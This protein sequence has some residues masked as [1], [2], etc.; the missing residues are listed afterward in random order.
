MQ[1]RSLPG[2][3]PI[4]LLSCITCSY[5]YEC[6]TIL[7]VLNTFWNLGFRIFFTFVQVK[8]FIVLPSATQCDFYDFGDL[9]VYNKPHLIA[10]CCLFLQFSQLDISVKG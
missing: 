9:A 5:L 8:G 6:E 3:K 7:Y 1:E 4:M 2:L 10:V